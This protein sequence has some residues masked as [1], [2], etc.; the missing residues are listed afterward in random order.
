M[1]MIQPLYQNNISRVMIFPRLLT[2]FGGW[3]RVYG[4]YRC[5]NLQFV[6]DLGCTKLEAP[7]H[8]GSA[9]INRKYL[10]ARS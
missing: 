5:D 2:A 7:G 1:Q 10:I 3:G 4:V 6:P 8:G 9:K